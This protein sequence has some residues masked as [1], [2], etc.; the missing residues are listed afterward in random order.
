MLGIPPT[1]RSVSYGGVVVFRLRNGLIVE[2]WAIDLELD[3][4]KELG[5]NLRWS[6]PKA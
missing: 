3:L 4:L 6:R 2:H 5:M 1:G